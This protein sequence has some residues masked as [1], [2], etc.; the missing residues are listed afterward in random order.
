MICAGLLKGGKDACG[1]DSGGPMACQQHG[2]YYLGGIISWGDGCAQENRPGVYT[3]I[4]HFTP[5]IQQTI[6]K[7]DKNCK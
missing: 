4:D 3:R 6:Q 1:G 5:W 2:R 7:L